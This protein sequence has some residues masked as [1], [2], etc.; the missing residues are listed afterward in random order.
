[1]SIFAVVAF[2]V[3]FLLLF[4]LSAF[5]SASETA[6]LSLSP[7]Q[8]QRIKERSPRLGK[9]LEKMLKKPEIMLSTLLIGNTFVN[10][11]LA[12]IGLTFITQCHWVPERYTEIFSIVTITLLVLLFGVFLFFGSRHDFSGLPGKGR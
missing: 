6:M 1:M 12:S 9:R 11:A 5:F 8:I 2:L 3:I 4:A 7:L 10:A